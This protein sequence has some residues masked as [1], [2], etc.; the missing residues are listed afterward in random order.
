[1]MQLRCSRTGQGVCVRDQAMHACQTLTACYT[2]RHPRCP[3]W[4][5]RSTSEMAKRAQ[6]AVRRRSQRLQAPATSGPGGAAAGATRG[7]ISRAA[8]LPCTSPTRAATRGR[9][10]GCVP[11]GGGRNSQRSTADL[12][13]CARALASGQ[14]SC[15]ARSAR[16]ACRGHTCLPLPAAC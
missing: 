2:H 7:R 4:A 6:E 8:Q 15:W 1:M 10:Q 11:W 5:R 9:R 13:L 12:T 16:S 3:S 14:M